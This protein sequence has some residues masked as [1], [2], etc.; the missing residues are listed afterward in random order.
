V[1]TAIVVAALGLLAIGIVI[2]PLLRLKKWLNNAPP[3]E[4]AAEPPDEG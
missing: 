1:T 3:I 2:N 4:P